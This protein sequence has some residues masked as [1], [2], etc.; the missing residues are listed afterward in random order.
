MDSL[1]H[2][3]DPGGPPKTWKRVSRKNAIKVLGLD[4]TKFEN[5]YKYAHI[6]ETTCRIGNVLEKIYICIRKVDITLKIKWKKSK[7]SYIFTIEQH[8]YILLKIIKS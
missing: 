8:A 3:A 4:N 6:S 7:E 2:V 1:D 5:S